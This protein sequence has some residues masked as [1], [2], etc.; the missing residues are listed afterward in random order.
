[1]FITHDLSV[2]R[3]FSNDIVVMYLGKMV[4]SAPAKALFKNPMHPYTKALLATVPSI[5]DGDD[6]E[7]VSIPG[8]VPEGYDDIPGCR[9]ADRCEY[10]RPECDKPQENYSFGE[11]H[12]AK[13]VVMKEE[14]K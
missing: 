10:R 1:M 3:H 7:L 14:E 13:C 5:Y 9:F 11:K 12:R 2:V 8:I 6:R 4:E